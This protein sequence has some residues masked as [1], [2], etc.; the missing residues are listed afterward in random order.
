MYYAQE[1]NMILETLQVNI[2]FL[3]WL[4]TLAWMILIIVELQ[5]IIITHTNLIRYNLENEVV[6]SAQTSRS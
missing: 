3:V 4:S 2:T 5:G 1:F 6:I